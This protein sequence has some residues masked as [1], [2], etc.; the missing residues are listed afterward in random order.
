MNHQP[1]NLMEPNTLELP[2]GVFTISLDFE[3]IWG[4]LDKPKWRQF[5]RLCRIERETVIERLL[6]LFAEFDVSASWCTVGH[7]FLDRCE[8]SGG[9]KHP[10]IARLSGTSNQDRFDRDPCTSESEDGIFYGRSLVREIQRCPVPQEIGCH[11]FS[12]VLFDERTCSRATAES[13]LGAAVAAAGE[14]G[15]VPRSFV[16]PRNQIGHLDLLGKHGFTCYRGRD[17]SWHQLAES[18]GA[19]H[20]IGHLADVLF[21]A[22]P[23]VVSPRLDASGLWE[24]PGSMLYT[25]SYGFRRNIPVSL[26]VTRARKGLARAASERKLFHLWF[27][28]TDLVE[29]MDDM[30]DG[31]RQILETASELRASGQMRILPMAGLVETLRTAEARQL[32]G[33]VAAV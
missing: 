21:A 11:S 4:T 2:S 10:E 13:E 14:M 16:F 8:A 27:H 31:L 33:S 9:R 28:P 17:A 12:H 25:P 1:R 20:R 30:F 24:I 15:I 23:P 18:R 19:L 22:E 29:R 3:L 5:Q 26:R 32:A 6:G 7:L